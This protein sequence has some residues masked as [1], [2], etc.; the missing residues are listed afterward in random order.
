MNKNSSHGSSSVDDRLET[1]LSNFWYLVADT[2]E[3]TDAPV[4]LKRL[5]QDIVVWRDERGQINVVEDRC[6]HRGARLSKGRVQGGRITCIY[7]GLQLDGDGV[8]T[9]TPPTPDCPFVGRKAIKSYPCRE[10]KGG[11]WVYFGDDRHQSPDEMI[12]P[13]EFSSD[14]WS[15]FLFSQV[16]NCNYQFVL[17]N[18]LD[19]MHG[20]YLHGDSYTLAYG[21]K[22]DRLLIDKT[23]LGFVVSR[24]NQ[25]GVNIDRSEL[26]HHP[27]NNIWIQTEIPYP[28]SGGGGFFRIGGFVTPIDHHSCLFWVF[29]SQESSGWRRDMWRFLYE[30][31]LEQ[32]HLEVLDQDRDMLES[33]YQDARDGE[34]L[35]QTDV[36]V[37]RMRRILRDVAEGQLDASNSREQISVTD[38][39]QAAP[40]G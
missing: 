11:I 2:R 40:I 10:L 38:I 23:D 18:R 34:W 25:R 29:R 1:G 9:A 15:S 7:H 17:D 13:E 33:I 14:K 36:G 31:R 24:R 5:N 6:P 21:N 37:T 28:A 8:I 39:G 3:I 27:E 12:L 26:F 20:S 32:R 22:Q 35:L 19:P 30:N 4:G 16:W